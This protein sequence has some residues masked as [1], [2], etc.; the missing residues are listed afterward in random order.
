MKRPRLTVFYSCLILAAGAA[1]AMHMAHQPGAVSAGTFVFLLYFACGAS[2]LKIKLPGVTQSVPLS[3]A[4]SFTAI[5]ELP[6]GYAFLVAAIALLYDKLED[7]RQQSAWKGFA[8]D[9]ASTAV[10]TL[11]T[12]WTYHWLL[13]G[14]GLKPLVALGAG[15]AVYYA[16][17]SL[18]GAV[19]LA[20]EESKTPWRMWSERFFWMGPLYLL[21]PV[22]AGIT[23]MLPSATEAANRMLGLA[24]L[25]GGYRY[26]K[27]YFGCLHDQQDHARRLDDIRQR[28]IEALAVAIEAKDGATAGHLRRVRRH[29][30]RLAEKL[31]AS[32]YEIKTLELGAPLHDVGKVG[33]PDYILG[34]PGCLTEQEFRQLSVHAQIGADIVTAVEFPYPVEQIVMNHHEH[35]DG[36]GYPRQLC[37]DQIPRL[38]RVL[39]VVDCFDALITDRPYRGALPIEKAV[40]IMREQRGKLFDP[41]ILDTFLEDVPLLAE[42]LDRE[43]KLERTRKVLDQ[44]PRP[45]ARQTW[46]SDG[47]TRDA[48]LRRLTLEKLSSEPEQLVLLYDILQVL[49]ASLDLRQTLQKTLAMLHRAIPYEIGGVFL[50]QGGRYVLAAAEGLPDHCIGRLSLPAEEGVFANAMVAQRPVVVPGAPVDLG[51]GLGRYLV[52]LRSTLAVPLVA[53]GGDRP[54]G[55]LLLGSVARDHFNL[56]QAWFVGLLSGKLAAVIHAAREVEALQA[57]AVTDPLSRLPNA[58][59]TYQRLETEV[60]RACRQETPLAVLF[61]DLDGFKEIND[62]HGHTAGDRVLAE[63]GERLRAGLRPYDFLGRVGGDEFV[64]ILPGMDPV[65]LPAKIDSLKKSVAQKLVTL[66]TGQQVSIRVSIGTSLYPEDGRE[67]DDLIFRADQRMY[68]E[69]RATGTPR[70]SFAPATSPQPILTAG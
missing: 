70:R 1:S 15:A 10:S 14:A 17:S 19:L 21:I 65:N 11:V 56:E 41:E 2:A 24:L 7:L 22:A 69:N 5:T 9:Q 37:G 61:L 36:S 31:C 60:E 6:A 66:P 13:E 54:A 51:V 53:E 16:V 20:F 46:M 67:A 68:D 29:A 12:S 57:E 52:N 26:I 58:R 55:G 38:A 44:A 34:K 23:A 50:L 49:G 25:Y 18:T 45:T 40:E 33:V 62:S 30:I 3:F 47:A 32:E 64:A 48:A 42:D 63:T 35:W 59:A 28:T 4:F 8:F 43:L 39:T 27:Q